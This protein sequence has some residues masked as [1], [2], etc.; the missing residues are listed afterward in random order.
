M[1]LD[2]F[3]GFYLMVSD[4]DVHVSRLLSYARRAA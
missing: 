2:G 3:A 1:F 4:M